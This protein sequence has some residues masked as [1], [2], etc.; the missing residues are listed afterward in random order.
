MLWNSWKTSAKRISKV[1]S[2]AQR[3][4]LTFEQQYTYAKLFVLLKKKNRVLY[5][6]VRKV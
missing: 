3:I 1:I 5:E 2:L 4:E 6:C